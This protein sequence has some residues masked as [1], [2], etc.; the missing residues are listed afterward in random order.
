MNFLLRILMNKTWAKH[1]RIFFCSDD[2][3]RHVKEQNYDDQSLNS[4]QNSYGKWTSS[5]TMDNQ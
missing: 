3:N 1:N 5:S 2:K 4:S